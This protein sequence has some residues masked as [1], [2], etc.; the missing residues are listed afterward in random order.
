MKLDF[1]IGLEFI[2]M[3][4]GGLIM[5]VVIALIWTIL[6]NFFKTYCNA[7]N[8]EKKGNSLYYLKD[9]IKHCY[10]LCR[11][12]DWGQVLFNQTKSDSLAR[13]DENS[14]SIIPK[15]STEFIQEE[16]KHSTHC[17]HLRHIIK[18]KSTTIKQNLDF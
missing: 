6:E 11:D 2:G 12:I 3:V 17:L 13:P 4:M 1:H 10:R 15:E 16:L 5:G 18:H 7:H 9:S 14:S 8:K